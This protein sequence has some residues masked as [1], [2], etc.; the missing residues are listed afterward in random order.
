MSADSPSGPRR[1]R[2]LVSRFAASTAA[3]A[4]VTVV[5]AV[6]FF[7][8]FH[9]DFFQSAIYTTLRGYSLSLA[10]PIWRD[11]DLAQ[12]VARRH[13]VGVAVETPEGRVAFAPG[14]EPVDAEV[15]LGGRR[16]RRIVADGPDGQR[17]SFYWDMVSFARG[18]LPLLVALIVL[19]LLMI[20]V[21]Y[22][23]QLAQLR[24]LGWLR[25][26]VDAVSKGDFTTRVPVVRNDEIGQVA[27]AFNGMTRRVEQMMSDRERLLGDVSHELR[28]PLARIKVALALLPA[29]DKRDLIARDVREMESLTT[30]L[31][32]RERV[33]TRTDRLETEAVDLVA[34][35][36]RIVRGFDGRPPGVELAEPAAAIEIQA[37][38]ALIGVLVKNLV[39]N[40]AKFSLPDSRPVEVS[41]RSPDSGV[42]IVVA[43][44][45]RGFPE[46]EVE[47]VFEPFVK[48]D[49]ARG[50]RTGYGLCL[51]L[52]R[53]IVEAHEGTIA[54]G[55]R[56]GRGTR[57]VVGLPA[58]EE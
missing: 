55:A 5:L 18:H 56:D 50:H 2:S 30:A 52:C 9:G 47:R 33:R 15:R 40:A 39:D 24:P 12:A 35:T 44:D 36:R 17:I 6:A 22:A 48:L 41:L 21:T 45:G 42:E 25:R 54:I 34:V 29:S 1:S 32:E 11:P 14:G 37:D 49:P 38:A 53:R 51:N 19:L 20:G 26:G 46:D 43:D 58:I 8:L 10:E 7:V 27:K 28:S 13:W 31:L 23:F 3:L 16:Y 57:V 4:A